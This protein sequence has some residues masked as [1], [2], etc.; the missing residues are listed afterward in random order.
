M[1]VIVQDVGVSTRK[2]CALEKGDSILNLAGPLG[3]PSIIEKFGTV[4]IVSGCFGS[5]PGY[6]LARALKE[7]GNRIIYIVEARNRDWTFWLDKIESV[8]DRL[9]VTCHDQKR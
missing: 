1:T 8:S 7:A 9:I 6:A 3:A 5:G 4:V 2:L